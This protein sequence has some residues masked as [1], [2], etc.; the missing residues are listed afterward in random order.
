MDKVKLLRLFI[1]KLEEYLL[2]LNC[3]TAS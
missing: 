3:G 1:N 2:R